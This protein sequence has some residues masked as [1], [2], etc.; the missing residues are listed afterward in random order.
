MNRSLFF[1][2]ISVSCIILFL[3][4]VLP[5]F[6]QDVKEP[7][8]VQTPKAEDEGLRRSVGEP[9]DLKSYI[10]GAEDILR[11]RVW[12]EPDLSGDFLV[13]PDGM[14]TLPLLNDVQAAGLTPAKLA[15]NITQG[16]SNY[17]ANPVVMVSL[18]GVYSKKY[19]V[20]GEVNRPGQYTFVAPTT[21]LQAIAIAGGL[22]EYAKAKDII[23]IRGPKRY[24]FNYRDVIKGKNLSQ[25]I[26]LESGDII[27]VP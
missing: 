17:V 1:R 7:V 27:N 5:A 11:V 21:V 3:A 18:A 6:G 26:L 4:A 22:R 23:V 19:F 8:A 9:V 24:K 15:E 13:R 14:I 16:L 2:T 20:V 12:R 25:N 10:I